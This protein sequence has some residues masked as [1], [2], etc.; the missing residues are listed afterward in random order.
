MRLSPQF[1]QSS[2]FDAYYT[3]ASSGLIT[4]KT[5]NANFI[6]D[7]NGTGVVQFNTSTNDSFYRSAWRW[8]LR[9]YD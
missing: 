5:T 8:S 2:L 3:I 4:P 6:L 7:G 9:A 1:G